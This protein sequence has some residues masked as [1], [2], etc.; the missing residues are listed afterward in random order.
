VLEPNGAFCGTTFLSPR[1]PFL[2]ARAQQTFDAAVREAQALLSGPG[3]PRGFRQWNVTDL[4]D[5]CLECGLVDFRADV[6][7]PGFVFFSARKPVAWT[8]DE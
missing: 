6:R 4:E 7:D 8:E 5:L 1:L 2:D 3:G